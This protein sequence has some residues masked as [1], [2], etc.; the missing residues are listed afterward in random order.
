MSVQGADVYGD[1]PDDDLI[2]MCEQCTDDA[3]A[4]RLRE[5]LKKRGHYVAHRGTPIPTPR[6]ASYQA[7]LSR[8]QRAIETPPWALKLDPELRVAVSKMAGRLAIMARPHNGESPSIS[9]KIMRS[10]EFGEVFQYLTAPEHRAQAGD[11]LVRYLQLFVKLAYSNANES[12][13]E[14]ANYIRDDSEKRRKHA[15]ILRDAMRIVQLYP[16]EAMIGSGIVGKRKRTTKHLWLVLRHTARLVESGG[17]PADVLDDMRKSTKPGR[18]FQS[19]SIRQAARMLLGMPNRD[20]IITAHLGCAGVTDN[21]LRR[22]VRA[23]LRRESQ[24][25]D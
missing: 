18:Y 21:N 5:L 1:V 15:E 3:E 8:I 20:A 14:D 13:A 7:E 25:A 16:A 19:F 4:N 9:E 22:T 23:L 11:S 17:Y 6:S 10:D 12:A 24:R 2:R